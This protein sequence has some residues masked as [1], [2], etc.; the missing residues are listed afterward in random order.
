MPDFS[1]TWKQLLAD[2][3]RERDELRLKVHLAK[4]DGRDQLAK[5]ERKLEQLRARAEV[6]KSTAK[7]S[8]GDVEQA[9]KVLASEI[10]EGFAKVRRQL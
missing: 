5:A 4:A 6:V 3:E 10:K 7:G 8:A 9:A 2:L 1:A